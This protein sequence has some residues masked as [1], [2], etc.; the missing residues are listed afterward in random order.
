MNDFRF[1]DNNWIHL[2]WI[3]AMIAGVL[4]FLEFRGQR[5]LER[6]VSKLMQLR[7]VQ[8]SSFGRRITAILLLSVSLIFCVFAIM[9]PQWGMQERKSIR[10]DSQIM[11]CLDVSKSMLAED[12]APNRL[13]RAKVE[14][15]TLLGFLD[16][17]QQ[18]GLIGFAGKATVLCPMTTDFGFLR[19]ILRETTPESVGLGGTRIGESL[20]KAI[21][22]FGESGDIN[23]LILLITDG[24][25]HDSFPLEAAKLAREKGIRIV[26]IG[27]GDEA[28][29]KIQITNP[30]TGVRTLVKDINGQDVISRLDGETLRDIALETEGAY[31]P[32]GTGVLDLEAICRDHIAT[33]LSGKED[34]ETRIIRNEAFQWFLIFALIFLFLSLFVATPMNLR[35]KLIARSQSSSSGLGSA[36]TVGW[37]LVIG[38][39]TT[40]IDSAPA[41]ATFQTSKT[42]KLMPADEDYKPEKNR[43]SNSKDVE[44]KETPPANDS[45]TGA[46]KPKEFEIDPSLSAREIYNAGIR[47]VNT[48]PDRA[49][50]Y[51]T[52]ARRDAKN[53]GELRY[54]SLYNLGWVEV[55]RADSLLKEDP[56]QALVHLQQAANRFRESIR[57]R[58]KSDDAR[59]NLEILSRRILELTDQL[60][61]K[62]PGDLAAR[63]DQ[64]IEAIRNH[65]T[66][67]RNTVQRVGGEKPTSQLTQ[68]RK[69]FRALGTTQ[70]KVISDLQ[71]FANDA[72]SELDVIKQKKDEEKSDEEK[73]KLVQISNMLLYVDSCSQRLAKA[74][75]LTR[76]MQSNRSFQR[77]SIALS[78]AKRARDQLR[79]PVEIIG[80]LIGDASEL[81]QLTQSLAATKTNLIGP[82]PE[83]DLP[84]EWLSQDYLKSTQ[85]TLVER[86]EELHKV[87]TQI[88][89]SDAEKAA[90]DPASDLQNSSNENSVQN[91]AKA[92]LLI[93]N[94]TNSLPFILEANSSFQ[95]SSDQLENGNINESIQSQLK[96]I[97][98]LSE[99]W[100]LFFD[101]RRLIE[102]TYRDENTIVQVIQQAGQATEKPPA[103]PKSS[104][105]DPDRKDPGQA[106]GKE[107]DSD[108]DDSTIQEF[109]MAKELIEA[110]QELQKKNIAR[111]ERLGKLISIEL[112]QLNSDASQPN[113]AQPAMPPS[114]GQSEQP[115]QA[116]AQK[117]RF[118]AASVIVKRI[119]SE[120]KKGSQTSELFLK[121]D[122]AGI[123][124]ENPKWIE[125]KSSAELA[126]NDIQ[127]LRRLFFSLIE[128]LKDTAQRQSELNDQTTMEFSKVDS[129]T[130]ETIDAQK[131]GPLA[132]RQKNLG[133]IS[134]SISK[135]LE[136]QAEQAEAAAQQAGSTANPNAPQNAPQNGASQQQN[137]PDPEKLL[138]ASQLVDQASQAMDF[139]QKGLEKILS[140]QATPEATKTESNT[141]DDKAGGA[142]ADADDSPKDES[143][144]DDSKIAESDGDTSSIKP[145]VEPIEE[146]QMAALQKLMEAISLL[147]QNQNDDQ[148]QNQDQNQD[149]QQQKEQKEKQQNLNANQLLQLIRDREAKRRK[150]KKQRA[151]S[152]G[153]V[154]KDW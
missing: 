111:S 107:T 110:S 118:E 154:E 23:R 130:S 135:E 56:K 75:S 77:W 139:S 115:D 121:E 19:L 51:L 44:K 39:A 151:A 84:P 153:A 38:A 49:E 65:Q 53:D 96:A 73:V 150:D 123:V 81:V 128:H 31:I 47:F 15:D 106:D 61:Q 109:A 76:R 36:T 18:V 72:R 144:K 21:D 92:K 24:E 149:Q 125:A 30:E 80:Q 138:K 108:N 113:P 94:I 119:Q 10:V 112:D 28:G 59:Y 129:G 69:E 120:L 33:L 54:S 90:G 131:V 124:A 132:N 83:S 4:I 57:I 148:N 86:G 50:L 42:E 45:P 11:V 104:S 60:N 34:Q 71:K 133:L 40:F 41:L 48:N 2:L 29:S 7:L 9:R 12:V 32:A 70:R 146:N 127:E 103:D 93:E 17:G 140:D 101:I 78:D 89:K 8:Q 52:R 91:D 27:F 13:E 122:A 3:V 62:E 35:E 26:S 137:G 22:G 143:Q 117:E 98:Q 20:L 16:E 64:Q 79:N 147:D 97:E 5:T 114:A 43:P 87:L 68:Y 67:L 100:E 74:R 58:P 25:D 82:K 6:F 1:A 141:S 46:E 85:I 99:A 95:K 55:N 63:L 142:N 136:K 145:D 134:D 152:Q 105:D 37:F 126:L 116:A 102:V 14:F 88:S 66:E